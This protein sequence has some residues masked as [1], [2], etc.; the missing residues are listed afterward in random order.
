M[1]QAAAE[2]PDLSVA[3]QGATGCNGHL[4]AVRIFPDDCPLPC[5]SFEE[6]LKAVISGAADKAVIPIENSLH[7]RV[8][9]IHHLPPESGLAIAGEHFLLIRHCLLA[10]GTGIEPREVLSHP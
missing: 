4:A 3:L 2:L 8:S 7:G 1:A 5:F 9:D 10:T 6:A